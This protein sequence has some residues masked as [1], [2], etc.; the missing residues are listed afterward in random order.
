MRKEGIAKRVRSISL[1]KAAR[2][3]KNEDAKNIEHQVECR[4]SAER[5]IN[6]QL[7]AEI[8]QRKRF[9]K[10][11]ELS[12]VRFRRL[13]ETAQD[14]IL[15]LDFETGQI[16][17]V[18]P[19]LMNLLHYTR[20]DFLGKKLW[21]IGAFKD[22]EA[23]KVVLKELQTRGYKRYENLPL[24]TKDGRSIEV[25]FVSNM[26]KVGPKRVIQC[27]IRDTSE[28]IRIERIKEGIARKV[29]HEIR[30]PLSIVTMGLSLMLD[31]ESGEINQ[32]QKKVLVVINNAI[33]RLIQMTTELLDLAKL[34][35]GKIELKK[36]PVNVQ[37]LIR[38]IVSFFE[39]VIE[40]KGLEFRTQ[41]PEKQ[42]IIYSDRDKLF[43]VLSN[44]IGNAVKFTEKGYIEI[45]ICEKENFIEFSVLDT[46]RGISQVD[47]VKIFG[48]FEQFGETLKNNDKGIG[49]GLVIAKD[50]VELS[51]GK[52]WVESEL[53]KG[54]KFSFSMPRG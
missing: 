28:R 37:D 29:Y 53:G 33:S 21:E 46:G 35:T 30:N 54:S 12:E 20:D 47:L 7:H 50:I 41:L 42:I 25:E 24:E 27:N 31:K 8:E 11:L 40:G 34:E 5:I 9:E 16:M 43:Q 2:K 23:S 36:E 26:Y 14:G 22:I 1:L 45:A 19:F 3:R 15:I 48:K 32:N 10:E 49:L 17:E 44:L 52:I 39:L 6:K 18:N 13:F 51:K 4:T 38:E